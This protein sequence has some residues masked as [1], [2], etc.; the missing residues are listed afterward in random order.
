[1]Q[2]FNH[3]QDVTS[4]AEHAASFDTCFSGTASTTQIISLQGFWTNA[5]SKRNQQKGKDWRDRNSRMQHLTPTFLL[6]QVAIHKL[7][8][9]KM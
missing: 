9:L 1:M 2:D 4:L 8:L 6:C 3:E 5:F 7:R